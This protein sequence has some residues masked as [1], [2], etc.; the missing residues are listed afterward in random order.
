MVKICSFQLLCINKKQRENQFQQQLKAEIKIKKQHFTGHCNI[1]SAQRCTQ[2]CGVVNHFYQIG[3][4]VSGKV[5]DQLFSL[6]ADFYAKISS[7]LLK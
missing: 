5:Y 1:L 4:R 2:P 7:F 6:Q 3:L